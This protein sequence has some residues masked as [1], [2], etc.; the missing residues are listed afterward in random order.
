MA[1]ALAAPPPLD[2]ATQAS[3]DAGGIVMMPADAGATARAMVKIQATPDR[4]WQ[5]IS[6]P[7]HIRSSTRSVKQL[8]VHQ[9]QV[10]A[11]GKREQHLGYTLK[12]AFT[13][14]HY[15]VIRVY[16]FD[17]GHMTWTLDDSRDNDI[18]ATDGRFALS[19]T[20]D[21]GTLFVYEVRL[22]SGRKLPSWL[23]DE[24]TE[25]SLKRFLIYVQDVAPQQVSAGR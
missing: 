16:D 15:N 3:L 2:S 6:D 7:V 5:V 9:D 12:V 8:V 14:V 20:A 1:A 17:A 25:S 10:R 22:D 11:D 4:V 18:V 24:L 13:E 21:G 19:P 23:Q